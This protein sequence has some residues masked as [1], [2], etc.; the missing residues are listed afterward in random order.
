MSRNYILETE[1]VIIP[2]VA[3]HQNSIVEITLECN[4]KKVL[5]WFDEHLDEFIKAAQKDLRQG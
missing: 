2:K 5:D 1:R 4:D 3:T